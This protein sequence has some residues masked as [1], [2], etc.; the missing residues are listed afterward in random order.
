MKHHLLRILP[1]A[2]AAL[3]LAVSASAQGSDNCATPTAIAGTGNFAFNTLAATTGTQGQAES[4][5]NQFS[6]T[7]VQRDVWFDWTAPSTGFATMSMCAGASN[8]TKIAAYPGAACPTNGTALACN[9]DNCGLQS[10]IGFN[11]TAGSHYMLQIGNFPGA[12]GGS[13]TFSMTIGAAPPPYP[14]C[15]STGPDVIVGDLIDILNTTPAGGI[16]ALAIG[17]YSCNIG[18]TVLAWVAGNNNHPVIGQSLYRFKVIGGAGRFE[19]VGN[20]WLKHGFT[21]LQDPLCCPSCAA[22]PNGTALGVGCADP[23]VASLNGNQGGLGPHWQV[24]AHTGVFTYPPAN[25][26]WSGTVARRL[27]VAQTDL[28]VTG[29]PGAARYFGE[30]QYV[31]KDDALAN[32]QNNNATWREVAVTG[33]PDFNFALTGFVF[34]A[35]S[36]IEAWPLAE[37]GVTMNNVQIPSD[38]K[39]IVGS[40]ATNLGAGQWHYEFAVYN[41]NSDRNVGS[42]SVPVPAG[43]TVTNIG[44]H[45]VAYHDGDGNSSINYTGTDWVGTLSGGAVNWACETQAVNNNAN[46]IRWGSTYN[47]RFDANTPPQSGTLTLGIWKPGAPASVN[48]TGDVPTGSAFT[49]YCFGDGTNGACPC[50]NNGSAGNGCANSGFASGANLSAT[51]TPSVAADSVT[52]NANNMTGSIAVFF[53]G[54]TQ[55]PP[56]VVDDGL[57]CV[58]GPIIRLGN[59]PAAGTSF[60]PQ[61][62]DPTVSVRGAIP[63]AGGTFYYQCFYRNA[64]AAFCPPATSNRTNGVQITW[65]P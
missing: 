31:T 42:F 65:A 45:D 21:A 4:L 52:L 56:A 2:L 8:D 58:G 37:T 41:M 51:G 62:G 63:P 57:G 20:S 26:A 1:T 54:A 25:P 64:V 3:G 34:P 5:C 10:L 50:V 7:G 60:Y 35:K 18:N 30:G 49:A 27:Q 17:T 23:Y 38:G 14:P 43:V 16:D 33:G 11:C 9:D 15:T 24:N 46:A 48:T 59:K 47:F 22:N 44:F 19:Q 61:P 40:K 13:G 36:A 55:V 6:T 28:E 39:L 29:G 32:N 12:A 53:Q